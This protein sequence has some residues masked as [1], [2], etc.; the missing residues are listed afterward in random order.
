M[1][2]LLING[3]FHSPNASTQELHQRLIYMEKILKSKVEG[4]ALDTQSLRR[5]AE[6]IANEG[7]PPHGD[8]T[9]DDD[10]DPVT[11]EE[12]CTLEP[13]LENTTRA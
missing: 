11:E 5:I 6:T 4:I 12:S 7:V 10:G 1:S 3:R 2:L 8:L 13:V 9:F